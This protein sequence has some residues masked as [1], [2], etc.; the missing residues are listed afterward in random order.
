MVWIKNLSG[1]DE[2]DGACT[3]R[4]AIETQI[5]IEYQL[6]QCGRGLKYSSDPTLMIKEPAMSEGQLVR[7]ASSA[8]VVSSEGD[9]KMLE[10]NGTAAS[11]VIEY[12]ETLREYALESIKGNRAKPD[13]MH[14]EQSGKALEMLYQ[15]LI[16]L[17]EELRISY[18]SDGLVNVL[19]MAVRASSVYALK[20]QGK[21][22]GRLPDEPIALKWRWF[23][24]PTYAD[25]VQHATALG[26]AIEGGFMSPD[27]AVEAWAPTVDIESVENEMSL[28]EAHQEKLQQNEIQLKAFS[29]KPSGPG[30]NA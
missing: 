14:S 21:P 15:P 30:A 11:A 13:T 17:V 9:A 1:G 23:F 25:Q 29:P 12:V 16:S 4:P 8:I 6:S 10:I 28:I 2:I 22:I 19:K 27:A 26:L 18:G 7:S 20:V 5:E 24:S 3:F